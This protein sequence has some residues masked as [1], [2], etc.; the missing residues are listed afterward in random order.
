MNSPGIKIGIV[1]AIA[2]IYKRNWSPELIE[3]LKILVARAVGSFADT[4]VSFEISEIVSTESQI[5]QTCHALEQSGVSLL[6][7][8]LSPYC[9]SALVESA[10]RQSRIPI[11]LWP[12]QSV[13]TV[14]QSFMPEDMRL[15]HGVHA[16]QDIANILRKNHLSF[17][18]MHHHHEMPGFKDEFMSWIRASAALNAFVQSSPIQIG[19]AFEHMLDLQI[20]NDVFLN[21]LN[22]KAVC[23][24]A[25]QCLG[26]LEQVSKQQIETTIDA[27][28]QLFNVSEDVTPQLLEK[29]ARSD[30]ALRNMLA[31]NKS[32]ACGINFVE[33]CNHPY[34]TDAMHVPASVLLSENIGYA[35]EGDWVT[36]SFTHALQRTLDNVSFSEIFTVGYSDNIVM[37][38]HFGEGNISMAR[39]KPK[40]KRVVFKDKINAEFLITDFEFQPGQYTLVN[41]NSDPDGQGQLITIEGEITDIHLPNIS[42]PRAVFSPNMDIKLLL[43]AY[44]YN[45]GSHHLVLADGKQ[46]EFIKKLARLAGWNFKGLN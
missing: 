39:S 2:P 19:G 17:G 42:G 10:I 45:G 40:I 35:A 27:Y 26:R 4:Q 8:A 3:K 24:S 31:E 36:A 43:D 14:S 6:V 20:G 21:K 5:T 33:I 28:K 23:I 30:I 16:V 32:M 34:I 29:T 15:S 22:L 46:T 37:L 9:P 44:A 25:G 38:R 11:L 7:F 18:V 12:I 13:V 1:V 41:L